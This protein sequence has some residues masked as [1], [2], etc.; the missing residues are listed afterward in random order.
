M[1]LQDRVAIVTGG[2][3]GI[4]EAIALLF[5][6]EGAQ[7][8]VVDRAAERANATARQIEAMGR[9]VM[10]VT[11]D[12]T[13]SQAI[14]QMAADVHA[15]FGQID[16]LVN[17]AAFSLGDDILTIDEATWDLNLN[18]VLKSVFLCAKAVLPT[19]I[20]QRRGAI[21][22]IASVNGMST[23]G[24]EA[25][26]AGKAGVINLTR[27]MATK[28]GQH[29]VRVN[30][31]CPGTIQTPLWQPRLEQDPQLFEKLADW[32]P[33]GRV[34]Q[35]EDVAQAALYLASDAAAWVTGISLVVD[36]GLLA[37]R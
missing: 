26:S 7:L 8:V 27:N 22:N 29:N 2:G 13:D 33:L 19:M 25:Y 36:G 15:H 10:V 3:S 30:V 12:V 31:I 37:A 14:Q 18:V 1:R 6:S 34:G 11:L 16:I 21:V 9:P 4:G 20:A 24:E 5:A 32:Y 35:P 23:F 17:N 28:Y